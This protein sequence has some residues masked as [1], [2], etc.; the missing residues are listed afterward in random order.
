[1]FSFLLQSLLFK[2]S[3]DPIDLLSANTMQSDMIQLLTVGYLLINSAVSDAN[4]GQLLTIQ[5]INKN[6]E[7]LAIR[8]YAKKYDI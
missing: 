1:M 8:T 3:L 2:A 7:E 6:K 5:I 4:L